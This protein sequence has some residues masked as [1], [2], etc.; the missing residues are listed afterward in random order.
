MFL[1]SGVL[2]IDI[3]LAKQHGWSNDVFFT[4]AY[5]YYLVA[6]VSVTLMLDGGEFVI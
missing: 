4:L 1:A 3:L 2:R 6:A 5:E